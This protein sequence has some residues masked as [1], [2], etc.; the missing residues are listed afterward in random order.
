[1]LSLAAGKRVGSNVKSSSRKLVETRKHGLLEMCMIFF[2]E[3]VGLLRLS[4]SKN[5]LRFAHHEMAE[6]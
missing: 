5:Q 2:L 3:G 4:F 6:W 1:V